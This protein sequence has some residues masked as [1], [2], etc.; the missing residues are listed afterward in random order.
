MHPLTNEL[1]TVG[2]TFVVGMA[3]GGILAPCTLWAWT[4][5]SST[6]ASKARDAYLARF[7][8]IG[9]FLL[10]VLIATILYLCAYL[11][12]QELYQHGLH[13]IRW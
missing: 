9:I 6:W 4:M 10:I 13:V 8:I 7:F 2:I 5:S 3:V 11:F 1:I 12:F